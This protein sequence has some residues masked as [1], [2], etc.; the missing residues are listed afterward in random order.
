[1]GRP[2]IEK[3][4]WNLSILFGA[5][6][7]EI[8]SCMIRRNESVSHRRVGSL[9]NSLQRSRKRKP[10][11]FYFSRWVDTLCTV[12]PLYESKTCVR[13]HTHAFYV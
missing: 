9:G 13:N 4:N 6:C 12:F 7:R 11:F 5:L 3:V 2:S 8:E 1:M 10:A